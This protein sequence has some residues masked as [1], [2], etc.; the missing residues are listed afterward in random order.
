MGNGI[1]MFVR[2]MEANDDLQYSAMLFSAHWD[3]FL[4]LSCKYNFNVF[5]KLGKVL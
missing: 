1:A 3:T 5:K 4:F 2:L